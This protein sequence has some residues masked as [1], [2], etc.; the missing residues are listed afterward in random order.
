MS[1]P[2]ETEKRYFQS[3]RDSLL[4]TL[5]G[6]VAVIH[7]ERLVGVYSTMEKAYSEAVKKVGLVS[8][9]IRTIGEVEQPVSIPALAIGVLSAKDTHSIGH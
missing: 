1:S 2:L 8:V 7:G 3:I 9:L 4:A 5:A 6:H